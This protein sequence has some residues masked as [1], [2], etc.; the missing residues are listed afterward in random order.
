[1]LS[2]DVQMVE[3]YVREEFG[4][5]TPVMEAFQRIKAALEKSKLV[6]DVQEKSKK[7]FKE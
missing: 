4:V 7:E 2:D 1:M 6:S 3:D 5:V